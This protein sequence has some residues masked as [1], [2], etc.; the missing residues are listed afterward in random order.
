MLEFSANLSML[1]N[2]V[3]FLGRFEW[4]ARAGFRG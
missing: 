1:F 2:E 4:A 3:D